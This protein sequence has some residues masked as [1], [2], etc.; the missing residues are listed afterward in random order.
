[1]RHS[2]QTV[3]VVECEAENTAHNVLGLEGRFGRK[4]SANP[5]TAFSA[6]QATLTGHTIAGLHRSRANTHTGQEVAY[7][8]CVLCFMALCLSYVVPAVWCSLQ[9]LQGEVCDLHGP[10]NCNECKAFNQTA[11]IRYAAQNQ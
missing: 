4:H 8:P 11:A 2:G 5:P 6:Q 9:T 3:A 7:A 1:M 10:R